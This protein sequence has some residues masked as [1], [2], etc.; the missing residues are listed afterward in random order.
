MTAM[1]E[2]TWLAMC[3]LDSVPLGAGVAALLP[4][5]AQVA[6]FRTGDDAVYAL[7]NVDPF[8]GAA[9]LS[10]GILGDRGGVPVV[11]SPMHKQC[12]ELATG[13]CVDDP[14]VRVAVYPVRV[15]AGT[16][17]VGGP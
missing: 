3:P 8:S 10:R 14:E 7:S 15:A 4:D 12:F 16:V 6:I 9:V 5:G 1:Q 11:A 2:R 13:Q 17:E